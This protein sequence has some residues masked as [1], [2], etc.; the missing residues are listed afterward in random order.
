MQHTHTHTHTQ[1]TTLTHYNAMLFCCTKK[2]KTED[3]NLTLFFVCVVILIANMTL[4]NDA[5]LTQITTLVSVLC[6]VSPFLQF[7]NNKM[8]LG[9]TL[10]MTLQPC[11]VVVILP[12]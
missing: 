8:C 3:A 7:L 11:N 2:A 4:C 10:F 5:M 6:F 1:D 9:A 12:H